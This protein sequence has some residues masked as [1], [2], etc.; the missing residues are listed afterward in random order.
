MNEVFSLACRYPDEHNDLLLDAL[1]KLNGV[2][3][4]QLLLGDGSSEI[5]QLCADTFT[6]PTLGT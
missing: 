3:H 5:L 6:G 1:A 4:D 2:N